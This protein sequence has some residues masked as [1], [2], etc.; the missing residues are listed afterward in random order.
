[1]IGRVSLGKRWRVWSSSPVPEKLRK[2]YTHYC[3]EY[4]TKEVQDELGNWSTVEE[5]VENPKATYAQQDAEDG[6]LWNLPRG[7][8]SVP[9][10][11]CN[12][13]GV[14]LD[15]IAEFS[16]SRTLAPLG[17]KLTMADATVGD[18]R[19]PPQVKLVDQWIDAQGGVIK[20]PTGSG[21][22]VMAIQ[23]IVR[24]GMRTIAFFSQK[25]GPAQW[26]SEF[27]KH[28]NVGE[29]EEETG[30]TIVGIY[31]SKVQKIYPITLT[32]W[33]VF[34]KS[35]TKQHDILK[36]HKNHFG[37]AVVDEC[38]KAGGPE[39]LYALSTL[40]PLM[41]LGISA[42]P[43][44]PDG[45][46]NLFHDILGP[47][48]AEG[49]VGNIGAEV[50]LI[51]TYTDIPPEF[52]SLNGKMARTYILK[53]LANSGARNEM[54]VSRALDDID[55]GRLVLIIAELRN[56]VKILAK[57][58]KMQGVDTAMA[59]GGGGK[60]GAKERAA[61]YKACKEGE[62]QALVAS[63][64]IEELVDIPRIAAVHLATPVFGNMNSLM[65]RVGRGTRPF[66]D[67]E[68]CY[69]YDYVDNG[70]HPMMRGGL[71]K[72]IA[73]YVSAKYTLV[74]DKVRGYAWNRAI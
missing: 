4:E 66:E 3:V 61:T 1:M 49:H 31:D 22:T 33:Q 54:I 55:A 56:H 23:A 36:E 14:D 27:H 30:E 52:N 15:N 5:K 71:D 6:F 70:T 8:V 12:H 42:T 58:L 74:K 69:V 53:H 28:T 19:Y 9:F 34:V 43:T 17:H 21:K 11:V 16:D 2:L 68:V 29:L 25:D 45:R 62:H 35:N 67:Q 32:T 48:V 72:R 24:M 47:I 37:V 63:K 60:K 18:R 65:Q 46:S 40:N 59:L 50:R 51:Q 13:L 10:K 38:H 57:M 73:T 41:F 44:R 64:V 39:Q 26:L 20:S 7:N